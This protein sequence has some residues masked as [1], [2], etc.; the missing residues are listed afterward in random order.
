MFIGRLV[1]P[2][3]VLIYC[4][5]FLRTG[6]I[7]QTPSGRDYERYG[8]LIVADPTVVRN[9]ITTCHQCVTTT[10]NKC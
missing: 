8:D 4:G 7:T 5:Q 9:R 1:T 10:S 6:V 3:D 2:Y